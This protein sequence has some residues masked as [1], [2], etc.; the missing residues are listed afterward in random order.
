MAGYHSYNPTGISMLQLLFLALILTC[1]SS[2]YIR[3]KRD[4]PVIPR[5]QAEYEDEYLLDMTKQASGATVD[6]LS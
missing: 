2:K 3:L 5:T 4:G 6:R 1:I